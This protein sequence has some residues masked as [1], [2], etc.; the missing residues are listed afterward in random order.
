M[1]TQLNE[2]PNLHCITDGRCTGITANSVTYLDK[3]GCLQT[4]EADST[5]LCVGFR[6]KTKDAERLILPGVPFTLIGDCKKVGT[7]QQAVRSA[8]DISMTL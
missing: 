8:F 7:V 2:L 3:D 6:A 5:V 1:D 4:L